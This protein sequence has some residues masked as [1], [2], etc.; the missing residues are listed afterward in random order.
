MITF[1]NCFILSISYQQLSNCDYKQFMLHQK[2]LIFVK[3]WGFDMYNIQP[4]EVI[5]C[6]SITLHERIECI[7]IPFEI[8]KKQAYQNQSNPLQVHKVVFKSTKILTNWIIKVGKIMRDGNRNHIFFYQEKRREDDVGKK[9]RQLHLV[10]L[11]L[12]P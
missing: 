10:Q 2:I 6:C 1:V 12:F 5:S 3:I 8:V 7:K 9:T 4:C 11:F